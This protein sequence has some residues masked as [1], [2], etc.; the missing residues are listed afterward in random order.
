MTPKITVYA[1][2]VYQPARIPQQPPMPTDKPMGM[3]P[4]AYATELN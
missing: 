4:T 3:E 1:P 2:T